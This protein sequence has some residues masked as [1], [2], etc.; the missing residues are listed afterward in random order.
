MNR[1]IKSLQKIPSNNSKKEI[2]DPQGTLSLGIDCER[3]VDGIGM[4]VLSDG[5]PFLNQRGLAALCG[6]QNAHIG[7]ISSQWNEQEQ[8][9]RITN[10]KNIL[11]E[12]G[13]ELSMP[14][15]EIEHKGVVNFCYPANACLAILEYY[16]IDAGVNT[17]KEARSNFRLLAGSKLQ[18]MI[19]SQVGYNTDSSRSEALRKWHERIELN[20][21]SAPTGYFSIFNEAHT[22]IYELIMAGAEIGEKMVPDISIGIAWAKHWD[23][24]KL[25]EKYGNRAKFPHKYPEDHPQAK[26]NPQIAN[27]YPLAALGEYR[28]WLES[29]YISGGKFKNYLNGKKEIPPSVAQLAISRL[30]PKLVE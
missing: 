18:D 29:S 14:H 23:A 1:E 26:S 16:A 28:M 19:Y 17:K 10:I 9:P 5:T 12:M 25:N 13:V 22:V 2:T 8:K 15:I 30:S 21:Q 27:C 3:D 24:E 11:K 7:T 4:G 20:H 6:V